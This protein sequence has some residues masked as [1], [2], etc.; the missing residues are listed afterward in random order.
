VSVWWCA[1]TLKATYVS[2]EQAG[3]ELK[4]LYLAEYGRMSDD[5]IGKLGDL[6]NYSFPKLAEMVENTKPPERGEQE[7]FPEL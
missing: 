2:L 7:A 3:N 4:R 6:T 1:H 5:E